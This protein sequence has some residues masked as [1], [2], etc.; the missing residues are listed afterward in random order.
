MTGPDE[1]GLDWARP[2]TAA[3]LVNQSGNRGGIAA[4]A[5]ISVRATPRRADA[6]SGSARRG[7]ARREIVA[8]RGCQTEVIDVIEVEK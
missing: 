7:V 6:L 8:A 3:T 4:T 1:A 2:A 5:T